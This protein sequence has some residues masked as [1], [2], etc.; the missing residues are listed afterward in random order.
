MTS[1]QPLNETWSPHSE[2]NR[3]LPLS[4]PRGSL[5]QTAPSGVKHSRH[6]AEAHDCFVVRSCRAGLLATAIFVLAS[7]F[8]ALRATNTRGELPQ[9]APADAVADPLAS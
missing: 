2:P 3:T 4:R 6:S 9:A 8:V 5:D 1:Q 7:A